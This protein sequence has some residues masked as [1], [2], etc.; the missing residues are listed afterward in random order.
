MK[1]W[2]ACRF[3]PVAVTRHC[4]VAWI[5][6]WRRTERNVVFPAPAPPQIPI[7][8]SLFAMRGAAPLLSG[9][10]LGERQHQLLAPIDDREI[11]RGA[12]G[13]QLQQV[14]CGRQMDTDQGPGLG[15]PIFRRY[16]GGQVAGPGGRVDDG[17][18]ASATPLHQERDRLLPVELP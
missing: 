1:V 3:A 8:I 9:N 6:A 4:G 11:E 5:A 13:A 14:G 18:E 7:L 15:G 16:P 10:G 12:Q 17:C 2:A